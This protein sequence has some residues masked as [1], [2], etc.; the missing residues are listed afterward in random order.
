MEVKITS[1]TEKPVEIISLVAGIS[2]KKENVRQN[3]VRNCL[4][5]GHSVSEFADVTFRIEGISR[6]CLA[7]LTRHRVAS[8]CVESQRYNK[9]QNLTE[10]TDWYVIPP[11]IQEDEERLRVYQDDMLTAAR[12]YNY[13]IT[14]GVPAEDARFVL[15]EATKTNLYMKINCRS[16][17]NLFNLRLSNHAQWEIRELAQQMKDILSDYNEEWNYIISLYDEMGTE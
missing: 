2:T 10:S 6:S 12:K 14:S 16:L 7:Q 9:Y 15:P 17:F 5:N 3:R 4:L 1:I 11:K 8:Y 13:M